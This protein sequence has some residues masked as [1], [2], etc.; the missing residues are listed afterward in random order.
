MLALTSPS[1]KSFVKKHKTLVN[2]R[3]LIKPHLS[4]AWMRVILFFLGIV[5]RFRLPYHLRPAT[6]RTC[7]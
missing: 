7:H 1:L 3:A 2:L 4:L 6:C 5:Y